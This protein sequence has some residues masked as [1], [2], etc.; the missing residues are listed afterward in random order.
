MGI[1]NGNIPQNFLCDFETL[2]ERNQ[3]LRENYFVR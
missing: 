3:P 1:R 2:R